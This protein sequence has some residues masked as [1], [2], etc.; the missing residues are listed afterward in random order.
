MARLFHFCVLS[1]EKTIFEG[2]VSSV[3]LPTPFGS[4]GILARH[5]PMLC[6]VEK[7]LVRCTEEDGRQLRI[8]VGDGVASMAEDGL[9]L[10]TADG[11]LSDP[12]EE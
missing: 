5:A 11:R 12:E 8:L 3:N 6:A 2:E 4:V 10:L 7:G 1:S 9:T